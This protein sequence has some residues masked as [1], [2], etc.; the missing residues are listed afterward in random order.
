M[1]GLSLTDFMVNAAYDAAINTL[2]DSEAILRLGP[3]DTRHF[4]EQVL[5]PVDDPA[6]RSTP[7]V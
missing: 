5:K 2:R 6:K 3:A 4:V 7:L 1:R